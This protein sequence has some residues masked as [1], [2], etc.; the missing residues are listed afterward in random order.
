[1]ATAG[2]STLFTNALPIAAGILLFAEH[3]PGGALGALRLVA[4]GLVTAGA[5]LLARRT[6][7][8]TAEERA[9]RRPGPERE[10]E[11]QSAPSHPV[12]TLAS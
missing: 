12:E 1:M 5:A 7:D 10:A 6:G 11:L 4:F 9:P 2:L 3:V 8:T